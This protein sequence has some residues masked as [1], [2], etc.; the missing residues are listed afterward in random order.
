MSESNIQHF[1]HFIINWS[2]W[3]AP[4]S[5]ILG[6]TVPLTPKKE[7]NRVTTSSFGV[8]TREKKRHKTRKQSDFAFTHWRRIPNTICKLLEGNGVWRTTSAALPTRQQTAG[9]STIERYC[10]RFEAWQVNGLRLNCT[11]TSQCMKVEYCIYPYIHI[12]SYR[13]RYI[14]IRGYIA[15]YIYVY[16][17]SI[18]TLHIILISTLYICILLCDIV[19]AL[20]GKSFLNLCLGLYTFLPVWALP[21][22]STNPDG[23]TNQIHPQN[24]LRHGWCS[25]Q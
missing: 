14:W 4:Q 25:S 16:M 2:L 9:W 23:K 5:P 17:D 3:G 13:Y 24:L 11:V 12:Y 10:C 22:L 6:G 19:W 8:L 1:L 15:I 18:P 21:S 7:A 20:Q